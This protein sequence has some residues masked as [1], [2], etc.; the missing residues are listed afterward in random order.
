M[1]LV[2]SNRLMQLVEQRQE[3]EARL[4]KKGGNQTGTGLLS[5]LNGDLPTTNA[6]S[7]HSLNG[8]QVGRGAVGGRMA[9]G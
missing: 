2:L 4:H 7:K 1:N 8:K 6:L 3:L 9:G 5:F